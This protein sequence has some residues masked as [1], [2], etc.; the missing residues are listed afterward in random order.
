[1]VTIVAASS[2]HVKTR[3]NPGPL[4]SMIRSFA[5][6]GT[7]DIFNG[8]DTKDARRTCP[9]ELWTNARLKLDQ[10]NQAT[11]GVEIVDYHR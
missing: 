5:A 7:Q 11:E 10:L 3:N 2:Y 1:M 9:V 6:R 8:P 4:Y